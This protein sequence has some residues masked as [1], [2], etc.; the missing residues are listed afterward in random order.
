M[1]PDEPQDLS[2][3][4]GPREK[5]ISHPAVPKGLRVSKAE[6]IHSSVSGARKLGIWH[7]A[8]PEGSG[9]KTYTGGFPGDSVVKKPPAKAGDMGSIPG[10]GRSP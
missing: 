8:G 5:K 10:P 9:D 3:H 6:P 4:L 1:A 2:A 7:K